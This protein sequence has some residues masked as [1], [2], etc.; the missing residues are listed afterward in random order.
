MVALCADVVGAESEGA[1][2]LVEGAAR[3]IAVVD[4]VVGCQC[5]CSRKRV[6]REESDGDTSRQSLR[7]SMPKSMQSEQSKTRCIPSFARTRCTSGTKA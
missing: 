1:A 5:R 2:T 3:G 6:V 4:V 7:L